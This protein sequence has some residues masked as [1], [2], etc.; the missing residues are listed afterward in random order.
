MAM[1]NLDFLAACRWLDD[2]YLNRIV[3][4]PRS[5]RQPPTIQQTLPVSIVQ[6]SSHCT[7]PEVYG[8]ILD[9]SPLS[10]SGRV[11][12]QGRA[13]SAETI[14]HFQVGQ[15]G[16]RTS[17]LRRALST[18][19]MPRLEKAGLV[20]QGRHGPLL[21]LP[22]NYLLFPFLQENT[23]T[24]LQARRPD[25]G[26][27]YRWFCP[28]KLLPPTYNLDALA[29]PGST[30]TIC[31]GITDVLSAYELGMLPIGLLG[32]M[33][34]LG[35]DVIERLVGRNVAIFADAD[36]S[37]RS[38]AKRLS[39]R[40]SARGITVV[41]KKLPPEVNDLNDFLRSRRGIS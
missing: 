14:A 28:T 5:R 21:C 26:K 15:I 27:E 31:E 33:R 34:D 39:E 40:L 38:L 18:F 4:E 1:H 9:Q 23:V 16:D 32:A 7:D 3:A 10:E 35:P 41:T 2:N 22:S 6:S 37:G 25:D 11:Y 8:W 17:L 19:G 20:M 30:I 24:Y 36:R 29:K 13:F 12:L